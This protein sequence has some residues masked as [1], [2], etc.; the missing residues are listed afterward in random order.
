VSLGALQDATFA[1]ASAATASSYPAANRLPAEALDAVLAS[2]RYG[3][4]ATARPDG[5]PH[6]T[7][8]SFT[9]V[10]DEVW[11][12]TVA[13]AVRSRNVAAQPWAVLVL[14]EGEGD[15]HLA[16]ILEGPVTA[17]PAPP[18]GVERPEWADVWLVLRPARV[19][20]YAAPGWSL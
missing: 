14:S 19:L 3:V 13:G 20:S 4:L 17:E 1:V 16:V 10:G 15:A 9:A 8:T 18:D 2:R 7:P 6:A 12:P 5:R 11:L